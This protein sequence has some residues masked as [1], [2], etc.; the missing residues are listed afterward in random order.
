MND[1]DEWRETLIWL[2]IIAAFVII[3][4]FGKG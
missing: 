3:A 4:V 2:A 1:W